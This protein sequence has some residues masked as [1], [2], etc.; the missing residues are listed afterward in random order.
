MESDGQTGAALRVG[1]TDGGGRPTGLARPGAWWIRLGI[2]VEFMTPGRPR[3]NGAHEQFHRVYKAEV[4]RSPAW[5]RTGQQRRS[6]RWLRDYNRERPHEGL[7]MEVPAGRYRKNRRRL[8]GHV[9]P[10]P[11]AAGWERRW[12]RGN[13]EINWRGNRRHVGEAFAERHVSLRPGARRR[14]ARRRT[15]RHPPRRPPAQCVT[16]YVRTFVTH[17]VNTPKASP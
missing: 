17:L 4:A 11:Y 14:S 6:T 12:V 15:R 10:W 13:G 2:A 5:N 3:E 9:P 16:H 1:E 8:P 7:G